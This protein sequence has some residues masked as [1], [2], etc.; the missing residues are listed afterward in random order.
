MCY[1]KVL[2]G[3][4]KGCRWVFTV[5]ASNL[6]LVESLGTVQGAAWELCECC[7]RCCSSCVR[8]VFELCG[9]YW[10]VLSRCCLMVLLGS[11]HGAG[12]IGVVL[13]SV[14]FEGGGVAPGEFSGSLRAYILDRSGR[15]WGMAPSIYKF[16]LPAVLRLL[17]QSRCCDAIHCRLLM[18]VPHQ[19]GTL[20]GGLS[21]RPYTIQTGAPSPSVHGALH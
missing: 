9:G 11:V 7:A 6:K 21:G 15:C 1:L 17:G 12:G 20:R 3:A 4:V 2:S 10:K 5:P 16:L 8:A 19:T 13:L 14:R 18:K